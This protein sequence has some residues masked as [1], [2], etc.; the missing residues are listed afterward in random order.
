VFETFSGSF[1]ALDTACPHVVMSGPYG[2][3]PYATNALVSWVI[4]PPLTGVKTI[5]LAFHALDLDFGGDVLS[6]WDLATPSTLRWTSNGTVAP[7]LLMSSTGFIV[8][9]ETSTS[10]EFDGFLASYFTTFTN[11]T[12]ERSRIV[13]PSKCY[14]SCSGNGQCVADSN[15]VTFKCTC[16][17]DYLGDLC[18]NDDRLRFKRLVTAVWGVSAAQNSTDLSKVTG[19]AYSA[20]PKYWRS[21][22][23]S[24]PS[25][26]IEVQ[27]QSPTTPYT[28]VAEIV[29]PR[30]VYRVSLSYSGTRTN[31]LTLSNQTTYHNLRELALAG[32]A[33][34][35]Q[36]PANINTWSTLRVLDLSGN[37]LSGVVTPG[38][39]QM[40]FDS[41]RLNDN[42]LIGVVPGA[43]KSMGQDLV[44]SSGE[45]D[46]NV[47]Y[48]SEEFQ[49]N[50][51]KRLLPQ[52]LQSNYLFLKKSSR[53]FSL[54]STMRL[55]SNLS[56]YLNCEFYASG[57]S[58]SDEGPVF[59]SPVDAKSP[60]VCKLPSSSM[61]EQ[62]TMRLAL[63]GIQVKDG[64]TKL[65]FVMPNCVNGTYPSYYNQS[66]DWTPI[67]NGFLPYTP[68]PYDCSYCP[69]GANCSGTSSP[70]C[71]LPGFVQ[72]A[73]QPHVFLKCFNPNGCGGGCLGS[74]LQSIKDLCVFPFAGPRCSLCVPGYVPVGDECQECTKGFQGTAYMMLLLSVISV[75]CA[76]ATRRDHQFSSS[77]VILSFMQLLGLLDSLPVTWPSMI[78]HIMQ[79]LD[80]ML[81]RLDFSLIHCSLSFGYYDKITFA[82]VLPLLSLIILGIY[83]GFSIIYSGAIMSQERWRMDVAARLDNVVA[84]MMLFLSII[85]IPLSKLGALVMS[86]DRDPDRAYIRSYPTVDCEGDDYRKRFDLAIAIF[87]CIGFGIPALF[88]LLGVV[89]RKKTENVNIQRR[90]G[91]LFKESTN[92]GWYFVPYKSVW[93]LVLVM[94]TT[95]LQ[96]TIALSLSLQLY[97]HLNAALIMWIAPLRFHYNNYVWVFVHEVAAFLVFLGSRFKDSYALSSSADPGASAIVVFAYY[98]IILT[99]VICVHALLFEWIHTQ[100]QTLSQF[101][102]LKR[103]LDS[104]LFKAMF[105]ERLQSENE[106]AQF[107]D[108]FKGDP[109][110]KDAYSVNVVLG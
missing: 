30:Y 32:I 23:A 4:A 110:F 93:G 53:D 68:T 8:K 46:A 49:S 11:N 26:I 106:R 62:F 88:F 42:Q 82:L 99:F 76:L 86:C 13:D 33:L 6:V 98:L 44:L 12:V 40:S 16:A 39:L 67:V 77:T 74:Q 7:T 58:E 72:S 18:N 84:A 50:G 20:V 28:G 9:L 79:P 95:L 71:A 69:F 35:G 47:W 21:T 78:R 14:N 102:L 43:W 37:R 38:L 83:F 36:I 96:N 70:P 89:H 15:G 73:K 65:G 80:N 51:C 101:Q 3:R 19:L 54:S 56:K 81:I 59:V 66:S 60:Y 87:V 22:A 94:L 100:Y 10:L 64:A 45:S 108:V 24:Y 103:I 27:Y 109:R 25:R 91:I 48:C 57:S 5:S 61:G 17:A 90:Y 85:H 2:S 107:H 97:L 104:A 1:H 63:F 29:L 92:Q 41:L 31:L 105:P 52:P 75:I 34:S 55:S